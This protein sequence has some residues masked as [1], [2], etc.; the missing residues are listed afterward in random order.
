MKWSSDRWRQYVVRDPQRRRQ[1]VR[2]AILATAW[3]LVL[4]SDGELMV[5]TKFWT[6]RPHGLSFTE[7]IS[8]QSYQSSAFVFTFFLYTILA[9]RTYLVRSRLCYSVESVCLS[10]VCTECIVAKKCVLE[11]TFL[12]T[13]YRKSYLVYKKWP[14]PLFRGRLRSCQP[15]RHIGHWISGKPLEIGAWSQRATSRKWPVLFVGLL[16]QNNSNS[17]YGR[18]TTTDV[19]QPAKEPDEN[20]IYFRLKILRTLMT[21]WR[22]QTTPT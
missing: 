15:L 10:S 21:L 20:I 6:T 17:S 9:D 8:D 19:R 12:L 7:L 1:A 5:V 16:T 2:L 4:T 14:W 11:Q 22:R 13:A 18:T 3:L